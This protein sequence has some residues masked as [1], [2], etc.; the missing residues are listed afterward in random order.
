[1]RRTRFLV[2]FLLGTA[3][4]SG[5]DQQVSPGDGDAADDAATQD[6]ND[7]DSDAGGQ[8]AAPPVDAG[9]DAA[10][11]TGVDTGLGSVDNSDGFGAARK[12][13]IDEINK[14]RGTEGHAAYTLWDTAAVDKCVDDQASYD[15]TAM[16]PHDAWIHGVYPSCNGNAQ[17]ECLGYGTS[18]AAVVACLDAM[19]DERLQSNCKGCPACNG[20]KLTS[21]V[22]AC[23]S[24][25]TCD[26]YGKYGKECGHYLNMSADYF[27]YA[28]CGFSTLGKGSDWAVQNFK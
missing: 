27:S 20:P 16:S 26:F 23:E 18:P 3:A 25:S 19:W 17:D 24:T 8:E 12:A 9:A 6:G 5:D 28:A 14:L 4:C 10:T 7:T 1:M 21:T 2:A 22:I 15:Q 13:C 11:D